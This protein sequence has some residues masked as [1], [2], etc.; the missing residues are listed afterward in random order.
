MKLLL[1]NLEGPNEFPGLFQSR[2][3]VGCCS[4]WVLHFS[5]AAGTPFG[6][7]RKNGSSN[8]GHC[9]GQRFVGCMM[10]HR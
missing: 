10:S 3:K 7:S 4:A 6:F 8:A 5:C 9:R 1:G 2:G